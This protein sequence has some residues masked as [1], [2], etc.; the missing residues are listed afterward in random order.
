MPKGRRGRRRPDPVELRFH[1]LVRKDIA[2]TL[3]A[4]RYNEVYQQWVE[5]GTLPDGFK[6]PKDAAEWKNPARPSGMDTWRTGDNQ[7]AVDTLLRRSLPAVNFK[8]P[9]SGGD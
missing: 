8:I 7:D 4:K 5:T 9:G 3:T 2:A 1:L 6:V